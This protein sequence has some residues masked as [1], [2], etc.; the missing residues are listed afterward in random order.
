MSSVILPIGGGSGPG[1]PTPTPGPTPSPTFEIRN[2]R[3]SGFEL[4][5]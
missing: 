2:W 1:G 3:S 4:A 5:E